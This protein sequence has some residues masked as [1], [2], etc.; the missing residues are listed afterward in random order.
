MCYN[1]NNKK[2][3]LKKAAENL[4]AEGYE[5]GEFDVTGSVNSFIKETTPTIPAIVNHN[6]I[7]LMNTFWGIKENPD[8][9]T[10]GKNL[11]SE[12]THTFYRKIEKNR[13]LIPASSYFEY[14]QVSTP[15]R[16]TPLKV[17]HEM[18]WKNKAQ[19]YIAGYFD[20]YDDGNLGFGLVTTLP[21]PVQAEIHNRMIITLD[22]KMGRSFLNQEPIETFQFPNYSPDLEYMN[23]EPQKMPNTLF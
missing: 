22:E 8:A 23:L 1:F 6:G 11:Q 16:K 13:C 17:K 20:I 12:N 10:K 19:F 15:G 2:V 3:N 4:N 18:F 9:P 7:V 14:K 5:K 21:N